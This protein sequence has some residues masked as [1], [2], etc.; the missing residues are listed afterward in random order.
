MSD[1]PIEKNKSFQTRTDSLIHADNYV[2]KRE[3]R[4]QC[5]LIAILLGCAPFELQKNLY[6]KKIELIRG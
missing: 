2:K 6:A 5:P 4:P 3:A 1:S